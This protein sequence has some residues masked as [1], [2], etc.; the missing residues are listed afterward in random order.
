[1]NKVE[2]AGH[3]REKPSGGRPIRKGGRAVC[4]TKRRVSAGSGAK[5]KFREQAEEGQQG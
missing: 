5:D 2:T 4:G 1:M 3:G